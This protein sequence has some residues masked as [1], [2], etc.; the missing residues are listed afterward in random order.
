MLLISYLKAMSNID[1]IYKAAFTEAVKNG[2]EVIT[3]HVGW[4]A[5]GTVNFI[6]DDL[7]INH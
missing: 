1:P 6:R 4:D 5:D 2:V 3:M 7:P